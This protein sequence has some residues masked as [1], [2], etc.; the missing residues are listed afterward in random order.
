[1]RR[2]ETACGLDSEYVALQAHLNGTGRHQYWRKGIQGL[3]A[4]GVLSPNLW[5]MV[6]DALLR[7]LNDEGFYFPGYANRGI[8][9]LLWIGEHGYYSRR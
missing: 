1:M 2:T 3:P 9:T 8:S 7:R 4:G 6:V 5:S